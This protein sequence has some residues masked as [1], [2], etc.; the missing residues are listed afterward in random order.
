[1]DE[2]R[3]DSIEYAI[4]RMSRVRP[5]VIASHS[6]S[7][8]VNI[9][10]RLRSGED[11]GIGVIV[12]NH[13]TGDTE[14]S[15]IAFLGMLS[16]AIRGR[17]VDHRSLHDIMSVSGANTA[18]KCGVDCAL[19]DLWGRIEGRS[20]HRL[21]GA[22]RESIPTSVTIGID[23]LDG[24][25]ERAGEIVEA[26]FSI[27]KVKAGIDME[28]DIAVVGALRE[29]YPD[30]EIRVDCNQGFSVKRAIEFCSQVGRFG[31]SLI[32]QP[33]MADD[34]EGL[35]KVAL[36]TELPIMA[37]ESVSSPNDLEMVSEL[38]GVEMVNIKLA[39]TGG[40]HPAMEMARR[41]KEMGMEVMVGCMSE[42]QASIS[43]GLHFALSQ[44]CVTMADLDSHLSLVGDPT[45]ALVCERGILE[46]GPG[47][48]L[49]IEIAQ[50][51]HGDPIQRIEWKAIR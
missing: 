49:G 19:H 37:D 48:G 12:P 29:R 41:C 38:G 35:S 18:A 21:L 2:I 25:L 45:T 11:Q 47:T 10:V 40:I 43:A 20:L 6:S 46:P 28:R 31:V 26:G 3:L 34:L 51:R 24:S 36:G 17:E 9:L 7:A 4:L 13:V 27:I 16:P 39:K 30:I 42:C 8:A 33:V 23:D 44:D 14:A 50:P 22:T 1:M 15:S 32:E 5:F